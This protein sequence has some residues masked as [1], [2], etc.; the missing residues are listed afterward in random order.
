MTPLRQ[1]L[2]DD[3]RLRNYSPKTIHAY[4]LAVSQL[5]RHFGRAPDLLGVDDIRAFQLQLVSQRVSWSRFNQ[6]VCGLR[7]FYGVTLGRADVVPKIP[8]GKGPKK[9]PTVLSPEEVRQL[10]DTALFGRERIFLETA[11]ALGLRIAELVQLQVD[12]IDAQ[13]MVV[14]VRQGKGNKDR[15]V[16]L[17]A[18]LLTKLRT[19]WTTHRTRPWLFPGKTPTNHVSVAG[20]QKLFQRVL[21]R[22]KLTKHASMH[23]LRHSYATHLLEAGVDVVTLQHLLGHRSLETTSRYLHVS[24]RA[25]KKMPSLL[26]LLAMPANPDGAPSSA[27]GQP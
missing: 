23:T 2:L 9:L 13:R 1:R 7:F 11:Y 26:D 10:I 3:M 17:S 18:Q 19:W 27:E 22:A 16:P 6:I 8:F 5:A 14:I 4:V 20:V 15:L 12:D 24:T 21:G 25:W